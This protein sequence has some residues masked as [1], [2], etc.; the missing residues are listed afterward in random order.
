[1]YAA[2]F[3][4]ALGA[5]V[6]EVARYK[7]LIEEKVGNGVDTKLGFPRYYHIL[8]V[9]GIVLSGLFATL[10]PV[11]TP[12][13]LLAYVGASAPLMLS[14]GTSALEPFLPGSK[15]P[16]GSGR[17]SDGDV[18]VND[19]QTGDPKTYVKFA[20]GRYRSSD[21]VIRFLTSL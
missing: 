6:L 20:K 12:S 8:V 21:G 5:A 13:F 19:I 11:G 4:G 16:G 17:A 15:T 9:I 3:F 10:F 1:M 7:K 2:F 18:S 14:K